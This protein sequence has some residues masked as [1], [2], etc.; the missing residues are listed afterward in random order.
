MAT[1]PLQS[2]AFGFANGGPVADPFDFSGIAPT[3]P[4]T[5]ENLRDPY[6][7]SGIT[8]STFIN[9][10][11]PPSPI[12]APDSAYDQPV[13][14]PYVPS[15]VHGART[16]DNPY[17]PDPTDPDNPYDPPTTDPPPPD[18]SWADKFT[19]LSYDPDTGQL[20]VNPDYFSDTDSYDGQSALWRLWSEEGYN[21]YG[22]EYTW[23]ERGSG[24]ADLGGGWR[25]E[26]YEGG[27]PDSDTGD[28]QELFRLVAP[29]SNTGGTTGGGT[30][31]GGTTGGGTTGGGTTGGG[32]TG[33][34]TTGGGTTGG[35]TTGGG[36]TAAE[37]MNR[38][39]QGMRYS[40]GRLEID[41]AYS[42]GDPSGRRYGWS[43]DDNSER[44]VFNPQEYLAAIYDRMYGRRR[45]DIP[46]LGGGY[47]ISKEAMDDD[48]SSWDQYSITGPNMAGGG[49]IRGPSYLSGGIGSL[50]STY[51]R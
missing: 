41:P 8:E 44:D 13:I 35:G 33:G 31:G 20:T 25:L 16:P 29:S 30:T 22:G 43:Y 27:E 36:T 1:D 3:P 21:D 51:L 15:Y 12:P 34:G 47:G 49:M 37:W 6:D 42:T 39:P 48:D 32:T 45:G 14:D 50:G 11:P 17:N 10:M 26:R 38:L 7:F 18:A 19:E 23:G 5:A 4:T 46:A 9:P 2:G 40:G 24:F 28:Y